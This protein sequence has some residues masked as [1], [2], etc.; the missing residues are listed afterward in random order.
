VTASRSDVA[1]GPTVHAVQP[2]VSGIP[3]V[4]VVEFAHATRAGQLPRHHRDPF[5][6]M[7]V[8]QAQIENLVIVTRDSAF[9]AYD[10]RTL[11][12]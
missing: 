11:P 4:L 8:A 7:L 5:D 12:C 2:L 9:D 6:R 1:G 10:V 3:P